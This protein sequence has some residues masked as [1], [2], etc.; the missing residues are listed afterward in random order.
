ML[1]AFQESSR[2]FDYS[3]IRQYVWKKID[4]WFK[5]AYFTLFSS[6][7]LSLVLESQKC[8]T[9]G[10]FELEGTLKGHL[11]Q[12]HCNEQGH[13]QLIQIAESL[14][15]SDLEYSQ[16]WDIHHISGQLVPVFHHPINYKKILPY[17][18]SDLF[19]FNL[20]PL[21]I[22]VSQQVLLK[23]CPQLSHRTV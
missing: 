14:V 11:V 23:V 21:P 3:K 19:S 9:I 15:L 22:A 4:A 20:M 2:T 7:I 8:G 16:R 17:I 18:L 1:R 6:N 5:W 10:Q 13:L 12:P